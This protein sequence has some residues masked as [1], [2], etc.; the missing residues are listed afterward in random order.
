[1]RI[2]IID[3]GTNTFNIFIAEIFPDKTFTKL[4]KSKIAVKLGEGGINK[5]HI[6]EKPF[7][8]GLRALKR[9]KKTIKKFGVD[10]IIA[11]ATSAIRSANNGKHFIRVAKEKIGID[12]QIISGGKEAEL[13]Y[14]GVRTAVKMNN[15]P[16]LIMD[17]GG[18]ST[19]F[20]IAN[21]K[22]ILWKQSFL[23]GAARL[24]EKFKPSDPIKKDEIKQIENY[25]EEN[26]QP[27]YL[28]IESPLIKGA[29]GCQELIGSSGSFDSLAEMIAYRFYDISTLKGK[30]FYDF[31][32]DDC[33]K[34]YEVLLKS[35]TKERL[36]MKGLT[37]MRVD[38]MV[39][40]AIFV[41]F[42]ILRLGLKKMRLSRY[43]LKEGVLWEWMN[44]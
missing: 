14:Y 18:G 27:L 30:T 6:E 3:L 19:E 36:R 32:F 28:A 42:I 13:I 21:K 38:M 8:R 4:Y 5:N 33:E 22:E 17:I 10:K 29:G 12:V 11:F 1:M 44:D 35:T 31:N 24:L 26:L 43:S 23:L 25:L 16:L 2:A 7:K 41:D 40:S 9:H 34:M 20:I 39:V 37:K 15:H